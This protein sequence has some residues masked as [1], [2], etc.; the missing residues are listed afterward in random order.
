MGMRYMRI[1]KSPA[2]QIA[3][4]IGNILKA[5]GKPEYPRTEAELGAGLRFDMAYFD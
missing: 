3:V 5:A 1:K 2:S 4:R